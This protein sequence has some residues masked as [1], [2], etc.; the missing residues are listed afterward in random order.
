MLRIHKDNGDVVAYT[1]FTS[2]W[3]DVSGYEASYITWCETLKC[4]YTEKAF[5]DM[6]AYILGSPVKNYE[7]NYVRPSHGRL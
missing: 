5:L 1:S 3:R 2:K 7:P 4:D 6:A